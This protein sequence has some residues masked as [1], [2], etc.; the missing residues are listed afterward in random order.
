MT[1]TTS[2]NGASTS[3]AAPRP[4]APGRTANIALWALQIIMAAAFVMA[5]VTKLTRY[6][7]AVET[8]QQIGLGD[9]FMYLIAALELA[10]A[11]GLLIPR[12]SGLAGL[13]LVGLLIG[14]V[15]T[16]LLVA[17]PVTAV[18]PGV[19]LIAAAAI[20]WGRRARTAELI[21]FVTRR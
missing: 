1:S 2:T 7:D 3:S 21:R 11:V 14:A 12:L 20:A 10:G 16:Q 17:E 9:W 6:P 15:V 18:V 8:F 19:Y 5:A 13:A 4:A